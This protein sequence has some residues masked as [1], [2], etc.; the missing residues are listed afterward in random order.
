VT[1]LRAALALAVALFLRW[2]ATGHVTAVIGRTPVTV[3]ALVV[4][5]AV[6]TATALATAAVAV[7][8]ARAASPLPDGPGPDRRPGPVT[9]ANRTPVIAVRVPR[10]TGNGPGSH[11]CP[12]AGCRQPVSPDRLMCRPHWYQVPKPLRDAVWVT[13]RSGTGAG[14]PAHTAAILAAISA[15]STPGGTR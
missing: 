12:A 7:L 14:T 6:V 9:T 13:W 15:A 10:G 5:A 11:L 4:T 2:L 8:T 3:P 1:R